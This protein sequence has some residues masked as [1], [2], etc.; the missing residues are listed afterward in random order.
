MSTLLA[1]I[2]GNSD[3]MKILS[4]TTNIFEIPD[5]I[6]TETYSPG[7]KLE[8]NEWH[9][10]DNFSQ[11]GYDNELIGGEFNSTSYNQITKANCFKIVYL[12]CK[13]DDYFLFQKF[14][15]AQVVSKKWFSISGDPTITKNQPIIV[16]RDF[17]DAMYD[18]KKDILY[19]KKIAKIKSMFR[20]I[21]AIYREATQE[22]VNEF[23]KNDF[24]ELG[25]GFTVKQIKTANRQRIAIAMDALKDL[26]P[27]NRQKIFKYIK[28]YCPEVPCTDTAFTI[29]TETH[30]KQVLFGIDQR[31][32][33]TTVSGE[34]RL[35]NS[36]L[37]I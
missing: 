9:K 7:Y 32:Y 11:S 17:V 30:L 2:T 10:I 35:A 31:Y 21:E 29:E 22:E 24:I 26:S 3:F 14:S 37:K 27:D 25:K 13:Q 16:L 34:K 6:E 36:V 23:I 19:F 28:E 15:P 4:D 12:C 20:G 8:N 33:T 1:K 18:K 5:Y